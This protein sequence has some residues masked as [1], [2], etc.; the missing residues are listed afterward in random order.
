M[1]RCMLFGCPQ[2]CK[3]YTEGKAAWEGAND[4]GY[5]PDYHPAGNH[6]E[7]GHVLYGLKNYCLGEN[8]RI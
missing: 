7:F 8:R 6:K 3:A 4:F 2:P 5:H 1:T